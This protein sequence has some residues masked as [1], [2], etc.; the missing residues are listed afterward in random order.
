[1][2]KMM[3]IAALLLPLTVLSDLEVAHVFQSHM[4]LQREKPCAIWGWAD[5]G[6]QVTVSFDGQDKTT[7]ADDHGKWI[8]KLDPMNANAEGQTLT[9]TTGKEKIELEDI[10]IGEVWMSAG[11][12][13]MARTFK[14]DK[15][16]Y[17]EE[18]TAQAAEANY[19]NMRFIR[20]EFSI[21]KEPAEKLNER[22][23]SQ[24][25][26]QAVTPE[27]VW[28]SFSMHY[29]FSKDLIEKLNVP[30]GML[31]IA[32]SGSSQTSWMC[33]E[34]LEETEPGRYEDATERTDKKTENLN[35]K[36]Q[37]GIVS[38]E[39]FLEREA[40]WAKEFDAA[41][42]AGESRMPPWPGEKRQNVH[43]YPC[44]LYN[45]LVHPLAPFTV[46]GVLWHQGEGGPAENYGKRFPVMIN[47]WRELYEQDFY[48]IWGT[49]AINPNAA[50]PET[51]GPINSRVINEQFL[52]AWDAL[53]DKK[54]VLCNFNDLG[55]GNLHWEAKDKAG[56]RMARA[57]MSL[58][59]GDRAEPTAPVFDQFEIDG[60][61]MILHFRHVGAG[62]ELRAPEG[63]DTGFLI[64]GQDKKW[65]YGN[66]EIVG[67]T[68]VVSHPDID[69]IYNVYYAWGENPVYS[70]WSKDGLPAFTFRARDVGDI[71]PAQP[72]YRK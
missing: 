60:N 70:L 43:L 11:Q 13:N 21:A 5:A 19:P 48:W 25:T 61:K 26:W 50:R 24:T 15:S 67:D 71:M 42:A 39:T 34:D 9:V 56:A 1:M 12:S 41:L 4:V 27:T 45:A 10:L 55:N 33:K 53:K 58:V 47:Q 49:I 54:A 31:Q 3:I 8:V 2:K 7:V 18:R 36:L 30:I 22:R 66:A 14:T 64:E 69:K 63:A 32:R 59:Y 57:A 16:E 44:T 62:L 17:R 38:L 28:D 51:A 68:V 35:K 52:I 20:Y 72:R 6:E 40:E 65:V 29:F 46:R 23:Y 37:D